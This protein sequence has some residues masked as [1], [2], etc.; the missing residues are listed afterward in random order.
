MLLLTFPMMHSV[1][2]A[3]F[4]VALNIHQFGHC[5][6]AE[7]FLCMKV[8]RSFRQWRRRP[9]AWKQRL[10]AALGV[11]CVWWR[12]TAAVCTAAVNVVFPAVRR[13]NA[14]P[15]FACSDKLFI[16][17]VFCFDSQNALQ[18]GSV[19]PPE[20]AVRS[21]CLHSL[22]EITEFLGLQPPIQ[23]QKV[24]GIKLRC[25]VQQDFPPAAAEAA[26]ILCSVLRSVHHRLLLL[27]PSQSRQRERHEAPAECPPSVQE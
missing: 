5:S 13:L 20:N 3:D 9:P 12:S 24:S 6:G 15:E 19:N 25:Q 8:Q 17:A 10:H 4:D 16:F 11:W 1:E 18:T 22:Q 2:D 14:G 23:I 26:I 21:C 27:Q 7:C